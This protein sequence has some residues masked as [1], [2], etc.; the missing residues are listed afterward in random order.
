[1]KDDEIFAFVLMPFHSDFTDIYRM[2]I[3]EPANALGIRAERVDEQIFSEGILDRI[4]RQ[5]D[6]ADVVVADMSEQNAN[7]FYEVGYAHGREKLCILLTKD[8]EDI[9]FDLKHHRHIVYGG[10]ISKLRDS[11]AEELAWA[12]SQIEATR[13]SRIKVKLS[14]AYGNLEKSKYFA[15]GEIDFKVDLHND[16]GVASSEIEAIYFYSTKSW[17]LSQDGKE[18]PYTDSDIPDFEKRHFINS[19][20]RRLQKNSWAQLKFSASKILA[21]AKEGEELKDKYR[22]TGRSILR[23]VTPD[24]NFDYELSI[25]VECDEIPF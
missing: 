18:C 12:K 4:Y 16:T 15:K 1:M 2:G 20:V 11:I 10:S 21:T 3:K 24:G 17:K 7:V 5:I 25:D 14:N 23:L 13:N 22:V 19:P 6:V 9:P 8:A